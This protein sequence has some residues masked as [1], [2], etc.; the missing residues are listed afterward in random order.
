MLDSLKNGLIVSC[1]ASKTDANA[2]MADP[3]VIATIAHAVELGGAVAVR[4]NLENIKSIKEKTALPVIGIKKVAAESDGFESGDFRITPTLK[5]VEEL[6]QAGA[7]AVAIDATHRKR[8]DNLTL[9]EFIHRIKEMFNCPVIADISTF[10]E[11]LDATDAGADAVGTTLA[12]YTPYSSNPVVFGT[13]PS[14]P[15]D[16]E[17]VRELAALQT[18]VIAEGRYTT[19]D[20]AIEALECGAH[21]VVVGTAITMPRKITEK[22][23]YAMKISKE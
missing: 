7:D 16:F 17:I 13:I 6:I 18:Y 15:P 11:G 21:A 2:E 1:Y 5:E 9:S 14:P 8:Y 3:E 10:Q 22:F 23:V 12:G 19:P 4:T 20:Q